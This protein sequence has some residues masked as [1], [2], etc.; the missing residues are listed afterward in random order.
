MEVGVA[1]GATFCG[2]IKDNNLNAVAIDNWQENIQPADPNV[3]KLPNNEK[4]NFLNNL[5]SYKKDNTVD[6]INNDLFE[7][8]VSQYNGKIDMW[9][10]DGPQL[11]FTTKMYLL[12]K[13]F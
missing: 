6:V 11:Y 10:Y 5:E 7:A 9:F 2:A 4:Q 13:L 8:D 12:K 1:Q 3:P